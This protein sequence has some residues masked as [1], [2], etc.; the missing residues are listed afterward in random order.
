MWYIPLC[1][2]EITHPVL[3]KLWEFWNGLR[4]EIRQKYFSPPARSLIEEFNVGQFVTIPFDYDDLPLEERIRI[5]P[6]IVSALDGRAYPIPW[7]WFEKGVA[8]V[9]GHLVSIARWHLGDPWCVSQLVE[10]TLSIL[11]ARH[12]TSVGRCP[13]RRVLREAIWVAKDLKAGGTRA[14]RNRRAR[15]VSIQGLEN[16]VIDPTDYANRYHRDMLLDALERKLAETGRVEMKEVCGL[17][18]LGHTWPEI[19][20]HFGF[21]STEVLKRRFYRV[22][23]TLPA[24]FAQ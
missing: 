10:L 1:A 20:E 3:R 24:S 19:A 21:A 12:G 13:W 6:I 11:F 2:A 18:R 22:L 9:H 17:V 14:H 4:D 8:P 15:E 16:A 23:Q 5:I 7:D